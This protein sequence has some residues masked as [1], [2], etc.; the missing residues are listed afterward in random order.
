MSKR[1]PFRQEYRAALANRMAVEIYPEQQNQ[2][3]VANMRHLWVLPARL[4]FAWS[5]GSR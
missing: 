4:D 5:G 3:N 1:S 2:I